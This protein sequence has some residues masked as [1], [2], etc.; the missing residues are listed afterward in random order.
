MCEFGTFPRMRVFMLFADSFTSCLR[1]RQRGQ[2]ATEPETNTPEQ[3]ATRWARYIGQTARNMSHVFRA[4]LPRGSPQHEDMAAVDDNEDTTPETDGQ[5]T[6]P[7]IT[8]RQTRQSNAGWWTLGQRERT[9]N[10]LNADIASRDNNEPSRATRG[11]ANQLRNQSPNQDPRA[12]FGSER[13]E[14]KSSPRKPGG[15]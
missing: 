4:S 8:N 14:T 15:G 10:Q 7:R 3:S 2:S 9:S 5:T 12:L 11:G 1:P 13:A 6:Q